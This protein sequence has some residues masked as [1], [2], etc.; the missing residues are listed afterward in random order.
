M[1][2]IMKV[3]IPMAM[4]HLFSPLLE[5]MLVVPRVLCNIRLPANQAAH[6]Q[7]DEVEAEIV[8]VNGPNG[9]LP[10]EAVIRLA[11]ALGYPLL[12]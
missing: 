10:R 9:W 1:T 3:E 11:A 4:S 12:E 2:Y 5:N 7:W 6:A 8:A